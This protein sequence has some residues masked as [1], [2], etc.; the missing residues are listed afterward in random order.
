MEKIEL[1]KR[2]TYTAPD[3]QISRS[4]VSQINIFISSQN[5][6]EGEWLALNPTYNRRFLPAL[7]MTWDWVWVVQH[8]DLTGTFPRR[9]AR[10]Y[11]R[12][13]GL[14]CPQSFLQELGNLARRHSSERITYNFEF[15]DTFDWESG[16]FGDG[17]SCYWGSHAGAR[18]MLASNDALAVCFYDDDDMGI[19]RAW[20]VP[21]AERF[22]IFNGYGFPGDPTLTI[23]RVVSSFLNL[24]YKRITLAN[25]QS[26]GGTLYINGGMGY[27]IGQPGRIA[28]TDH[29]DFGWAE[30]HADTCHHCGELL[31]EWAIYYGPDNLTFCEGCYC[32]HCSSCDI[33]GEVYWADEVRY[34]NGHDVCDW[35]YQHE[36]SICNKCGEDV[37]NRNAVVIGGRTF[38][39]TC[40]Q[41]K[42]EPKPG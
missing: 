36:Y 29:H 30:E 15:V 24:S 22:I 32:D 4:G 9:V 6:N 7:P 13:F 27:M 26:I 21:L 1:Y 34:V 28:S 20:F 10:H 3:G 31:D 40:R 39:Q 35:C 14:R 16:D 17:G 42:P 12:N 5:V 41:P 11:H 8:G 25:N 23:A 18:L 37:R 33:C 19:A 38:C 2:Q